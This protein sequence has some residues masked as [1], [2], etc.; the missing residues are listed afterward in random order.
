MAPLHLSTYLTLSTYLVIAYAGLAGNV[1]NMS[2]TCRRHIGVMSKCC[3]FWVNMRIGANTKI[4]PTQKF[5]IGN[6]QQIV[7]TVVHTDTVICAYCSTYLPQ[8]VVAIQRFPQNSAT[9]I[10][11]Y[12][13]IAIMIEPVC[14]IVIAI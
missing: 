2:V 6:H 12:A 14:V 10:L 3:Q 9:I 5:C 8:Q 4:T 1:G 7:V 11:N 13:T